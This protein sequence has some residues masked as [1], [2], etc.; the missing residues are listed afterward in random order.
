[1][2]TSEFIS[3]QRLEY[4]DQMLLAS[5]WRQAGEHW[6]PPE[7]YR[8]ALALKMSGRPGTSIELKRCHAVMVQVQWDE[9]VVDGRLTEAFETS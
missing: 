1:M 4:F 7:H 2:V 8:D 6:I 5:G 9:A 3:N